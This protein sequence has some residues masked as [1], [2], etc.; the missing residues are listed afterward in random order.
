MPFVRHCVCVRE[1]NCDS[2]CLC[3]L[4]W[5]VIF[6]VWSINC[7][8]IIQWVLPIFNFMPYIILY[9][10]F[11]YFFNSDNIVLGSSYLSLLRYS[12]W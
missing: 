6:I 5:D 3:V 10:A 9:Q 11:E 12:R 8:Y 4:C 7:A 1:I 2:M